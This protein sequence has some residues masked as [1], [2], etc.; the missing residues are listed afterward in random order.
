MTEKTPQKKHLAAI[1]QYIYMRGYRAGFSRATAFLKEKEEGV[2][3][4]EEAALRDLV[5]ARAALSN[6]GAAYEG[7]EDKESALLQDCPRN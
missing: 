3:Y 5:Q 6:L 1:K 2:E 4:L 7:D